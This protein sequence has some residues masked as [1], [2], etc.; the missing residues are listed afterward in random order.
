MLHQILQQRKRRKLFQVGAARSKVMRT[1]ENKPSLLFNLGNQ[2]KE[3]FAGHLIS[4]EHQNTI[5]SSLS[6]EEDDVRMICSYAQRSTEWF[7]SRKHRLS[8]SICG[9]AIGLCPYSTPSQLLCD[10]FYRTFNGNKYTER[11]TRLEPFAA[12][13][14][15]RKQKLEHGDDTNLAIPGLIVCK[16][17][18]FLAYS[19]DGICLTPN[20]KKFLVEIKAP[21]SKKRYATIPRQYFCQVQLGMFVLDLEKCAFVQILSDGDSE[22]EDDEKLDI[23]WIP[24]DDKFINGTLLPRLTRFFFQRYLPLAVLF[25]HGHLVKGISSVPE[26]YKVEPM[27]HDMNVFLDKIDKKKKVKDDE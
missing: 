18:P 8:G 10:L 1:Y 2:E 16:D 22:E 20:G 11:G 23:T 9:A 21:Y 13:S 19:A 26:K 24:R 25:Q 4:Q 5:L 12:R 3:T 6:V 14:F 27:T 7:A 15:L 17:F